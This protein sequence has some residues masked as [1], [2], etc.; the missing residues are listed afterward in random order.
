MPR[1]RKLPLL[2]SIGIAA[3]ITAFIG[4]HALA[5]VA[6]VF[7]N[8]PTFLPGQPVTITVSAEDDDSALTI[9]SNL[10]GSTLTVTNCTGIGS[11]QV[12]GKCDGF[13][14]DRCQPARARTR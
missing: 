14:N 2:A 4:A 3:T 8:V 5:D 9:K 11:N 13:R 12:A 1:L 6:G 10:A 7:S